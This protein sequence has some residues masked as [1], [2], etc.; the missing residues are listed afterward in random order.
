MHIV[1]SMAANFGK[2]DLDVSA[3]GMRSIS[4]TDI[5]LPYTGALPVQMS[6]SSGAYV[7]LNVQL[8]QGA[9]LVLVAHGKGKD[10]KRPL[11]ASSEEIIAL[12]DG[13]F[14]QNQDATGLAQ[15]WLGVWQAHYTEWRKIVTGP[16]RLL[17][18]LS[19]LSVTDRE[20]LCKHMM[21]A[22][23]TE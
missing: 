15:Y 17:T 3:V 23:A 1:N 2:Y 6:A 14:K 21:D 4:E 8:A 16:D 11:E 22:P 20:F 18:I 9:R 5:K 10:I 7:Y 19:S 13:F 12:L